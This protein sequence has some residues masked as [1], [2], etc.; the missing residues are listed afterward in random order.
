MAYKYSAAYLLIQ[1]SGQCVVRG[2]FSKVIK[3]DELCCNG[4]I[5]HVIERL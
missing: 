5:G 2:H 3:E 4:L 1:I